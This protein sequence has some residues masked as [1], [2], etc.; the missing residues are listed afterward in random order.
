MLN[1]IVGRTSIGRLQPGKEGLVF[2]EYG[3]HIV[4]N[5]DQ[6]FRLQ[7][8]K[9]NIC[10]WKTVEEIRETCLLWIYVHCCLRYGFSYEK[11]R[12]TFEIPNSSGE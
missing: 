7:S 5:R 8:P 4:E 12:R 2:V 3:L 9:V 1:C 11:E 6:V 10:S